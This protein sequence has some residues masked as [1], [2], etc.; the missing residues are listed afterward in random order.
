MKDIIGFEGL[1]AITEDGRV[2]SYPRPKWIGKI[3]GKKWKFIGLY[4][5]KFWYWQISLYKDWKQKSYLFHREY[6]KLYLPNP[7]NKPWINHK[8]WDTSDSRLENLE[9]CTPSE[10][11]LHS[12]HVIKTNRT[13]L[14]HSY[15]IKRSIKIG[16]YSLSW[17]LLNIFKSTNEAMKITNVDQW[18]IYRSMTWEYK[19]A[20]WF[21]WK[22]M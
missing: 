15:W 21:I 13:I 6:A 4:K 5:N 12:F 20:W 11:C 2:W 9:W 17:E 16:Q 1:Y 22:R 19:H 7:D 8:N 10:N 3:G 14:K 18:W